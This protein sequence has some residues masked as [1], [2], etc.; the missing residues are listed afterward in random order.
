MA[1]KGLRKGGAG[2]EEKWGHIEEW[3]RSGSSQDYKSLLITQPE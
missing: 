3:S 1:R 2:K